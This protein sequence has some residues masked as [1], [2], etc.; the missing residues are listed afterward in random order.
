MGFNIHGYSYKFSWVD[1]SQLIKNL[2]ILIKIWIND[3]YLG[4]FHHRTSNPE[5]N[6]NRLIIRDNVW[7]AYIEIEELKVISI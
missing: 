5:L 1:L 6:Y 4:P 3:N 2:K 7:I